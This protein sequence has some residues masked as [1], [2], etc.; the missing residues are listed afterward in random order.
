MFILCLMMQGQVFAASA[1]SGTGKITA[2]GGAIVR[3]TYSTSAKTI[4]T[5]ANGKAF[6]VS[7]E[8]FTSKTST[9]SKYRWYRA[10]AYKGYVRA[11]LASLSYSKV[12]GYTTD[13]VNVRS[14]AGTAFATKYTF[15]KGKTV[16]VM[17]RAYDK[18][19]GLW[20]KIK[21]NSKYYYISAAYVKIGTSSTSSGISSNSSSTTTTTATGYEKSLISAG[22]PASYASRLAT[23]HK[24]HPNWVFK[25]V[26]TGLKWSSA[27]AQMT[28]SN[29][30]NTIEMVYAPSYRSTDKGCYNYLNNTYTI[31]DGSTWVTASR[32][33]VYYYMDPRNWLD[34]TNIFMFEDDGYNPS[35]QTVSVVGSVVKYNSVLKENAEAFVT[36][37][38]KYD[39]NPIYLASKSYTEIGGYVSMING[40]KFTYNG[41]KY[42]NCFN[43]YNIGASDGSDAATRGLVYANGGSVSKDYARGTGTSYS[44]AW[45]TLEKAI[46]G[47]ASYLSKG[48]I[49]NRQDTKYLEHFNVRN[50]LSNVGTHVY[51]TA[52]FGPKSMAYA[53]A[54][55]YDDYGIMEKKLIFYIPVYSSMPEKVSSKPS[56]SFSKDNNYYLKTLNFTYGDS[57]VRL[58]KN[59]KLSYTKTFTKTVDNTVDSVNINAIR[60]RSGATVSGDTGTQ[61]LN[62][63][64][65]TFKIKCKSS[66]GLT[67]TYTINIVR[68]S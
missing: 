32:K 56:T 67:R 3:A 61:A 52:V 59:T 23:L 22:F 24:A 4:T 39:I 66:S 44:R 10:S 57:T 2:S 31:R 45:S 19:G 64:T 1:S 8:K 6:R 20:Y 58:I 5:L 54:S 21:Y 14:G 33:A 40:H 30:S 65:N 62:P 15:N 49:S 55:A 28:A 35:Y 60:A 27:A 11:D 16:S 36:A 47:G 17:L 18:S 51:M 7:S 25:P 12:S 26:N 34:S 37:G 48:Y 13:S 9:S 50:G 63:G 38:S 43:A 68:E 42:K 46:I 41:V 53:T 29:G